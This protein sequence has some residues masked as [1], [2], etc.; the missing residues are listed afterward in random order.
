MFGWL[1]K[2]PSRFVGPFGALRGTLLAVVAFVLTPAGGVELAGLGAPEWLVAVAAFLG[3]ALRS[4]PE[5]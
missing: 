5:G 2:A 1:K 3:T 4:T